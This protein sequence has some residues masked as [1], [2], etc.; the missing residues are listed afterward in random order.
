LGS[1]RVA[2]ENEI[3]SRKRSLG[4]ESRFDHGARSTFPIG[5]GS[6]F[7]DRVLGANQ[8]FTVM[9]CVSNP[10][11]SGSKAKLLYHLAYK[12]G[13]KRP[14]TLSVHV[15]PKPICERTILWRLNFDLQLKGWHHIEGGSGSAGDAFSL[16]SRYPPAPRWLM[17]EGPIERD[18]PS[19]ELQAERRCRIRANNQIEGEQCDERGTV[20]HKEDWVLLNT[21]FTCE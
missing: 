7:I 6:M 2:R 10:P 9:M 1:D 17:P 18:G 20:R 4:S 8:T 13:G 5:Q 14:V 16:H 21:K 12:L 15:K 11:L 19:I 3:L